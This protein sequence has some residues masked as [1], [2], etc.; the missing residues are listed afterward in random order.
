MCFLPYLSRNKVCVCVCACVW[1]QRLLFDLYK[2]TSRGF[3][4]S[5]VT[6]TPKGIALGSQ[7]HSI[8]VRMKH[9]SLWIY[10]RIRSLQ[11]APLLV[12]WPYQKFMATVHYCS[13][14]VA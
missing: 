7:P 6:R 13:H 11:Y 14:S 2:S 4:R 12:F 10:Y 8:K 5:V 9:S 3:S 1:I